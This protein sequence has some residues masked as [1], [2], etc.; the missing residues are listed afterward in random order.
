MKAKQTALDS[1]HTSIRSTSS[2]LADTRRQLD[3]LN[4]AL[5]KQ[6]IAR[7][8]VSNLAYAREEE[9]LRLMQSQSSSSATAGGA[10][11]GAANS[12]NNNPPSSS[13]ETEL[14]AML[15]SSV[16]GAEG[17]LPSGAVLRARIKAVEGRRDVT[18]KMVSALQGRSRDVEVKYRRVV[19]LCTG[20]RE[21]EVDAVIDG[22][23]KAV[24]SEGEALEIDRVRRF[25]TGV[26]VGGG[27]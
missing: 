23:L 2:Q 16:D 3:T 15:E 5:K 19:A 18:R 21:A 8:Q 11:A 25:L 14:S 4:F 24:E 26:E 22:L 12:N 17:L 10:A 1:L 6:Q 20:V 13:W 7:Q 9:Q 27:A